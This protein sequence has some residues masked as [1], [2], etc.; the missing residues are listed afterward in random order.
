MIVTTPKSAAGARDIAVPPHLLPLIDTHLEKY[1]AAGKEALLFPAV[2]GGHLQPSA[3]YAHFYRARDAGSAVKV[4][5]GLAA[6]AGAEASVR[7]VGAVPG[8]PA[9]RCFV[10]TEGAMPGTAAVSWQRV[11]WHYKCIATAE[12]YAFTAFSDA[13]T[14]A[15]QQISAQ[16][17]ILAGQ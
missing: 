1:T 7:P 8:L 15:K 3:L 10:R 17:R 13:E 11:D 12:R 14:D 2:N 16:Y 6:E 4:A 9:A 5:D